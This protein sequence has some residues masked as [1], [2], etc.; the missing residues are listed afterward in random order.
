MSGYFGGI[1]FAPAVILAMAGCRHL[2]LA[3]DRVL[4]GAKADGPV[5]DIDD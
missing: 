2:W 5:T 3:F 4:F 1:L